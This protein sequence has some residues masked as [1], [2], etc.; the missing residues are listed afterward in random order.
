ME[1]EAR[2]GMEVTNWEDEVGNK[3]WECKEEHERGSDM[4]KDAKGQV[5]RRNWEG[6][7]GIESANEVGTLLGRE[8]GRAAWERQGK[9]KGMLKRCTVKKPSGLS[10]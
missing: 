1:V 4:E 10:K 2:I 5:V 7:M 9:R 6:E 3:K 8:V